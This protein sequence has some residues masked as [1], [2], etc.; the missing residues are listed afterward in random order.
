MGHIIDSLYFRFGQK[1]NG[2]SNETWVAITT[3]AYE[4]TVL[5]I[6]FQC[7]AENREVGYND[8]INRIGAQTIDRDVP[9]PE[10]MK[11]IDVND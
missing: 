6:V 9:R 3:A 10:R 5:A 8:H 1:V 4:F 7:A 11:Y 2:C